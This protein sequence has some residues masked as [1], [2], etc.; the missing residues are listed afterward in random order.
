M[1]NAG[2]ILALSLWC[3]AACQNISVE[4]IEGSWKAIKV[5]DEGDSIAV[6]LSVATLS[7]ASDQTFNYQLTTREH[8]Y[9]SYQIKSDLLQ[10]HCENPPDTIRVQIL[11]LTPEEMLLRMN[12]DGIERKITLIRR[13]PAEIN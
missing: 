1:D 7:L 12:H 5:L 2:L 10:L 8:L 3:F 11:E 6:D 13:S 4:E 9:G